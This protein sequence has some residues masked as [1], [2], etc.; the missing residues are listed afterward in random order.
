MLACVLVVVLTKCII[1][2]SCESC[3]YLAAVCLEVIYDVRGYSRV[4][5]VVGAL[6]MLGP[7]FILVMYLI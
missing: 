2:L 5:T 3:T 4:A 1:H 7:D 6:L